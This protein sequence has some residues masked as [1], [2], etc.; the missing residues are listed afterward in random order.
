M[1][2]KQKHSSLKEFPEE[3]RPREKLLRLGAGAL[4]EAELLAIVLRTGT[5]NVTAIQLAYQLL[6]RG[7][8]RFLQEATVE[9]L[10]QIP[11]MGLAKAAQ[12][13][14]AVELGKRMGLNQASRAVIKSPADVQELL[15]EEMRY[16]DRE[17]FRLVLLNT[18]N[19]VISVENISVGSLNS[20]LVHPREVFKPAIKRS[21]AAIILTH[22]HPSG[23]PT[24]SKED[25]EVT[26]RLAE[27][28]KLLGIE[29][30][31]HII[32]GDGRIVSLKE[33]GML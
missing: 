5:R 15:M 23:D 32:F 33:R 19:Q 24:P 17:F 22:N 31:D 27:A 18:K 26:R 11:G 10:S 1:R 14:S 8:L 7:G 6:S 25:G 4:S 2:D 30:L 16:L 20:S 13:K 9:E 29:V 3:A 28:G 12:V 21:A